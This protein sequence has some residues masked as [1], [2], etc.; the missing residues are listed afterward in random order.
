MEMMKTFASWSIGNVD[1]RT[2][3]EGESGREVLEHA[4][5]S[6]EDL[7]K[8]VATSIINIGSV[9]FDLPSSNVDSCE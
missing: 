7:E 3:G 9:T 6:L 1:S 8:L 4:V 2:G 5:R